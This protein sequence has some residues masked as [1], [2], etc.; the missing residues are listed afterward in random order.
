MTEKFGNKTQQLLT[1][2]QLRSR[3]ALNPTKFLQLLFQLQHH[4]LKRD[5][6]SY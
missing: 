2:L 4:F 1:P 3:N 5:S 6:K